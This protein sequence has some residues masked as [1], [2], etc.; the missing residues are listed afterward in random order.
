[1]GAILPREKF[2]AFEA[3]QHLFKKFQIEQD[4][5]IM[6]IH[7]YHGREFENAQFEEYCRSYGIQHEFSSP[8]T[9][10]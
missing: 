9:P 4:C 2:D 8:I 6:W 3:T 7:S 1:L 10:H 5:P